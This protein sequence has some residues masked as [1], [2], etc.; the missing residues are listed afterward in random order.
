MG[1]FCVIVVLICISK[2]TTRR[3][4]TGME[5]EKFRL[6]SGYKCIR[7]VGFPGALTP[8]WSATDN[9]ENVI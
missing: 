2:W 8:T 7:V 9:S 3:S 1:Y 6:S 5:A 4:L